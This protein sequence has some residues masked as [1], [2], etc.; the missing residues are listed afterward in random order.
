MTLA[1]D[2]ANGHC[3]I[4]MPGYVEKALQCFTHP[5]PPRLQHSPH[6][7]IAPVYGASI[8]YAL[9]DDESEPLDKQGITRLQQIIGTLLFYARAVDNTMLVA[10]G[11]I[12]SA[13][14][15]G[16]DSTMQATMQLLDYA[17]SHPDAAVRFHKSDMVLYVHSDASYLSVNPTPNQE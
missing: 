6:P 13:Q 8:Q 10:L 9:L 16:T 17:A 3:T 2:Y 5:T 7:W 12:A 15:K 4:S 1:W 11:T 14:T